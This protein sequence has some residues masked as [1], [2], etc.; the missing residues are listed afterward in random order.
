LIVDTTGCRRYTLTLREP[1]RIACQSE[2]SG[3]C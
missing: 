1:E 3:F 2:S